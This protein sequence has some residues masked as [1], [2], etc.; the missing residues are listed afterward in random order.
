MV[1]VKGKDAVKR[2]MQSIPAQLEEKVLKGA[3]RAGIAAIKEEAS[4]RVE[5]EEVRDAL[6]IT[7]P[8]ISGRV[9]STRLTVRGNW[10]KSLANWLEYGTSPHVIS[11]S[12]EALQGRSA[13]RINRLHRKAEKA[14]RTGPG[15][16]LV[17]GGRFVGQVVHH[18][19]SRPHPFLR[20]SLDL[21]REDAYA[22]AQSY[23][24]RRVTKAGILPAEPDPEGE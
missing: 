18:P 23:I 16:E 3:A 11:G 17:I 19:G 13:G 4:V 7:R 24:N 15:H 1:T 22:A 8:K 2:Y 10:A 5:S 21:K 12:K 9:V 6:T 20:V 14:G